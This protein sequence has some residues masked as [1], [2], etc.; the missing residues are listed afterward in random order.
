MFEHV[1][2]QVVLGMK[3]LSSV[4]T[5]VEGTC[6]AIQPAYLNMAMEALIRALKDLH[7]F[8]WGGK[9]LQETELWSNSKENDTLHLI[10]KR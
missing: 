4:R 3:D 10:K 6:S 8:T 7:H 5:V 1:V 2:I 9:S